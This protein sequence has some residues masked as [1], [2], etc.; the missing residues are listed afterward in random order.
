LVLEETGFPL[1]WHTAERALESQ[2]IRDVIIATEDRE[3]MDVVAKFGHPHIYSV[4]TPR[5]SSGTERIAWVVQN[6][7]EFDFQIVVNFQG[8]EPE[9]PGMYV[10]QLVD[11]LTTY[12]AVDVA[13]LAT[14][15][16]E[17]D[18]LSPSVVKVVCNNMD[19]AMYFSRSPIP[20][21]DH[22]AALAHIGIY[23]YRLDFLLAMPTLA[24]CTLKSERLE[25]LQWLESGFKIRVLARKDLDL[26]GI[27]TQEEYDRFVSRY[28][29]K[30]P[31]SPQ[32]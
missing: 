10:D 20:H 4:Q 11:T 21:G 25:Q 6:I 17:E 1:L 26:V 28:K 13:T 15:I 7:K 27:D 31:L 3:I 24:A 2:L 18:Y 29:K 23:A 5:C 12:P 30:P 32:S 22:K 14:T 16:L 19:D 8:D 9:L